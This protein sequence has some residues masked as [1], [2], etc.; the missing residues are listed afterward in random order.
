MDA[1]ASTP[2]WTVKNSWGTVWGNNGYAN[3]EIVDGDGTCGI[4]MDVNYPTA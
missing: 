4:N 3:F 1:S 2:Y